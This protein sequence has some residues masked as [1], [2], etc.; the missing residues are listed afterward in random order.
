MERTYGKA[1]SRGGAQPVEGICGSSRVAGM[2]LN[3][4]FGVTSPGALNAML[5]SLTSSVCNMEPWK[6]FLLGGGLFVILCGVG[7]NEEHPVP[8]TR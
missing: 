2:R 6:G 7:G 3:R 1:W 5:R 8:C 4:G